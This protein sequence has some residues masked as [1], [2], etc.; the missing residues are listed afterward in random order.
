[1]IIGLI[2]LG[3][4]GK[5]HL[6]ELEKNSKIKQICLFDP[7]CK[8]NFQ[9]VLYDDFDSFLEE[10]L[11][12]VIIATPTN[13]HLQISLKVFTRIKNVLIEKPLALNLEQMLH[14]Q[15]IAKIHKIKVGI[16]FCER[17]NPVIL[18]LKEK[19]LQDEVISINIQRISL[20]PQRI[21]DVGVLSDLSV[22]DLDLL[23]FLTQKEITKIN[24]HKDYYHNERFEDEVMMSLELGHIL[25][26]IHNSWNAKKITRK[27]IILGKNHT[28]EADLKNF[29]LYIDDKKVENLYNNSPLQGEHKEFF[30]FLQGA[31]TQN[32]ASIE[33]ALKV[34]EIL[35]RVC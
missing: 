33:D 2:G 19:L 15:D 8:E 12:A 20:Y 24:I 25:A 10:K 27:V 18:T 22:H 29:T 32:L 17:F 30:K 21:I 1:M 3:K 28:Y 26:S 16:G 4:M 11:D 31:T 34:Q 13:T 14:I 9:H 23:R 7:F 35:E 5:N 6:K